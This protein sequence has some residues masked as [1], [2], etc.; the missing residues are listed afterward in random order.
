MTETKGRPRSSASLRR[1]MVAALE[2]AGA[3]RSTAVRRAFQAIPREVFVPEIVARDG[4]PA[5]YRPELALATALD[6]RGRAIS[7]SSAP[8]IMGLMLEALQLSPGDRVLEVGAGTGY[9]AALLKCLVGD[10]GRVTSID[11]E[12]SFARRAKRALAAAGFTCN[13]VV[14]DGREGWAHAA[15]YDRII[16][17][18]ASSGLPQAW[19]DQLA[20]DGL[21]E[22]P[23]RVT[24]GFLPQL[25]VT[26]RREGN[27][28][29]SVAVL[30]GMFMGLRDA[31]GAPSPTEHGPTVHAVRGAEGTLT[32]VASLSGGALSKLS[33]TAQQRALSLLLGKSRRLRTLPS[34]SGLGLITFLQLSGAGNLAHCSVENRYGVAFLGPDGSSVATVTR[35]PGQ[36][37]RVEVWGNAPAEHL[38]SKHVQQWEHLGGPAQNDL[39]LTISY[40]PSAPRSWRTLRSADSVVTMDWVT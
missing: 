24:S 21:I 17:T 8:T 40:G 33:A 28:L 1:E 10:R 2:S 36:P 13:I 16:V 31:E 14:G 6:S 27:V 23:L 25:V 5:I 26:L 3:V 34:E 4:L 9:N 38:F 29:R 20:E 19:R 35:A 11:I 30:S 39:R 37:A 18:A 32:V 15:P 12:S 7:S 22:L